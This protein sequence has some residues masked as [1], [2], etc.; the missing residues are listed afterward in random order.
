MSLNFF[1]LR[2][3]GVPVEIYLEIKIFPK[4][5]HHSDFTAARRMVYFLYC[6]EMILKGILK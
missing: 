6:L 2:Y 3:V 5:M 4:I 1:I